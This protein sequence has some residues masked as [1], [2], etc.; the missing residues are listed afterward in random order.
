MIQRYNKEKRK[1]KKM[2]S[3][4]DAVLNMQITLIPILTQSWKLNLQQLNSLFQKYDLLNYIDIC[5]EQ[6]N[7]TGNQGIIDELEDYIRIQGGTIH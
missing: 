7:S 4:D 6:F 1:C 5:Y 2:K 3:R